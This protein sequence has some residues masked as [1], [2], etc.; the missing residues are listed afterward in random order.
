MCGQCIGVAGA[1]ALLMYL[2]VTSLRQ[3]HAR[4]TP[5]R[6]LFIPQIVPTSLVVCAPQMKHMLLYMHHRRCVCRVSSLR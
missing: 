5:S 3:Q 4:S 6:Y 2:E 1:L